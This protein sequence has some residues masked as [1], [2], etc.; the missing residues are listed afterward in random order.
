MKRTKR[1]YMMKTI[2]RKDFLV[3]VIEH[4]EQF[5]L[6]VS[7]N[8]SLYEFDESSR[9]FVDIY[10]SR[11]FFRI[12][13]GS[14]EDFFEQKVVCQ[15]LPSS[16]VPERRKMKF[17]LKV[18]DSKT[19]RLLGLIENIREKGHVESILPMV[20]SNDI[21][22]VFEIEWDADSPTLFINKK[23]E[24]CLKE[25]SP[26][27]AEAAFREI[28]TN[29]FQNEDDFD[30]ESLEENEWGKFLKS[31]SDISLKELRK[32]PWGERI[33]KINLMA[34]RFFVKD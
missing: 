15:V 28:A 17:R 19:S 27:I 5:E 26:V 14:A 21:D 6:E 23:L 7:I 10:D 4:K 22:G 25:I 16:K 12:D 30:N 13:L 18:V 24:N 11:N 32:Y 9:V 31:Y 29:I 33:G 20:L 34:Q 3:T 2:M 8:L 1:P